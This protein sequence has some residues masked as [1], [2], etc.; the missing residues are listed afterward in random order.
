MTWLDINDKQWLAGCRPVNTLN[1]IIIFISTCNT[2][3]TNYNTLSN[4]WKNYSLFMCVV[5]R[6]FVLGLSCSK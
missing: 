4:S 1:K 6:Y 5:V 2:D 3:L